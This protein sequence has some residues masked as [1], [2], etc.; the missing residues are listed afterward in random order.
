M[1]L[2]KYKITVSFLLSTSIDKVSIKL[3]V[4]V[5]L[6]VYSS[7]EPIYQMSYHLVIEEIFISNRSPVPAMWRTCMYLILVDEPI[8]MLQCTNYSIVVSRGKTLPNSYHVL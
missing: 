7:T 1:D 6:K 3:F 8:Q 2:S 4:Y 5:K